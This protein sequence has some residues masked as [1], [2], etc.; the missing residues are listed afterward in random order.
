MDGAKRS[1]LLN[2]L[3]EIYYEEAPHIFLT[4]IVDLHAISNKLKNFK[5]M[6]RNF[7]YEDL[8]LED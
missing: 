4:E 3:A 5:K 7:N 8:V 1:D 6:A 2:Q